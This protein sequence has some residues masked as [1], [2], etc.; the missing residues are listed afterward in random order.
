MTIQVDRQHRLGAVYDRLIEISPS[1]EEG[2]ARFLDWV[3]R[4]LSDDA[5]AQMER[6]I[7]RLDVDLGAG[8]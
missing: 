5:L 1:P 7:N 8:G 4:Y 6:Q 3:S 2:L